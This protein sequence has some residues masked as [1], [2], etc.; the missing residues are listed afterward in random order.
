VGGLSAGDRTA[1]DALSGAGISLTLV[2]VGASLE[3]FAA[4]RPLLGRATYVGFDPDLRE[5]HTETS[6]AGRRV[7]V[8]KAVV[9]EADRPTATFFLTRNPTASST[10]RPAAD[11]VAPYL[12]A[13]RYEVVREA[14]VPAT[15]LDQAL[16]AAGLDRLDWLK[17]DTQGTD[18]R[19]VESLSEPVFATLMAVD[20]EPGLDPY[21]ET[22]DTFGE[23]HRAMTERG[24]WLA[25]IDLT[26]AVRLRRST[27][28]EALGARTKFGRMRDEFAL[29]A[30]PIAVG[31]RYLRTLASLDKAG[32]GRD[33]Y[34][35]LWACAAFSGN[36][37][38]A[39]DVIAE[40]RDRHGAD[41]LTTR[42]FDLSVRRNRRDARRGSW[43][44]VDKVSL[45][46][47]KR[48][49]TKSY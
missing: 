28:D 11:E 47:L 8:N 5:M 33:D 27:Y 49:V 10:L 21:Y 1:L 39:L 6:A 4:F 45:R 13:Y 25:D 40:C 2:D 9:A 16:V 24:F 29:K 23:L 48:F 36:N 19:L 18:L 41:D 7:I 17:L 35:R 44:L 3:P 26:P 12:H 32:A 30:S 14:E 37:P 43:R 42:L 15:T 34:L 20:A 38:F 31:P 46:N 22:E